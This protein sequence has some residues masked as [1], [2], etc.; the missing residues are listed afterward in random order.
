MNARTALPFAFEAFRAL[1]D[2]TLNYP[3]TVIAAPAIAKI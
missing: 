1:W 2:A 3:L